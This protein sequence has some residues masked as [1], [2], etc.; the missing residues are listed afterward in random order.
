MNNNIKSLDQLNRSTNYENDQT[1]V[2]KNPNYV[3]A[4]GGSD[5]N[6]RSERKIINPADVIPDKPA[7]TNIPAGAR[8][9]E[10]ARALN[11]FDAS[12]ERKKQEIR[13]DMA[14]LQSESEIYQEMADMGSL[15]ED[16][17][18][19]TMPYD[20]RG[21]KEDTNDKF[22]E[23]KFETPVDNHPNKVVHTIDNYF[24]SIYPAPPKNDEPNKELVIEYNN[25]KPFNPSPTTATA[26]NDKAEEIMQHIKPQVTQQPPV[27]PQ[28]HQP[29]PVVN[30]TP[31]E[32]NIFSQTELPNLQ[33]I[34]NDNNKIKPENV[35]NIM[36]DLREVKNNNEL[37][38]AMINNASNIELPS[39]ID[40]FDFE[41]DEDIEI[42]NDDNMKAF[43]SDIASAILPISK[44][45]DIAAFTVSKNPIS[46]GAIKPSTGR[47]AKWPLV[48]TGRLITMESFNGPELQLLDEHLLNARAGDVIAGKEAYNMLYTHCRDQDKPA[49][50]ES[51]LNTIAY[52]DDDSL[53]A[54]AYAVCF[55][56][57]NY[58]P[59]ECFH[60]KHMF[61]THDVP[62]RDMIGFPDKDTEKIF[63]DIYN[64]RYSAPNNW[65]D[66]IRIPISSSFAADIKLPSLYDFLFR[67]SNF[68]PEFT[69]KYKTMI[70][71]CMYVD[72]LYYIDAENK[73]LKRIDYKVTNNDIKTL[74]YKIAAYTRVFKMINSD[75]FAIFVS[76]VRS[77]ST[78]ARIIDYYI[79]EAVCPKCG[80]IIPKNI[81]NMTTLLFT[82]HRLGAIA[83]TSKN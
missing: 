3:D 48:N 37:K 25:N 2:I 66:V 13:E 21:D 83:T 55:A 28:Q 11:A 1:V 47:V 5:Y 38:Q 74:K 35:S 52:S 59:M 7:N 22:Y 56:G 27:Q 50:M 53:F 69:K 72:E 8:S 15:E 32:I 40:D 79:P 26:I 17:Q 43:Q 16:I 31:D 24:D 39:S 46:I 36:P 54:C 60:D 34:Q 78:R 81:M 70:N 65:Y 33:D 14:R 20:N 49:T 29:Q 77:I 42:D 63:Y 23:V 71:V 64:G 68:D 75:E 10:E 44:K 51:W 18:N 41:D 6:D 67:Y 73:E 45:L 58:I 80:N 61:L 12:I 9:T 76:Y 30:N 57:S 19:V 62:I 4:L 82:R